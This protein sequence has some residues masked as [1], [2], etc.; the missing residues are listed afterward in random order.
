[1]NHRATA[2]FWRSYHALPQDIRDRAEK[3]FALLKSDP[4][5]P[6]LRF[7]KVGTLWSARVG[8]DHRALAIEDSNGLAWIWIGTHADYDRL[9]G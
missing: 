2:S 1:V 3:A 5:H 8:R 4:R 7:K 6:S 9:I